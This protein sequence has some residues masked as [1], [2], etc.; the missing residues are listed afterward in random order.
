VNLVSGIG[1]WQSVKVPTPWHSGAF[2]L[3]AI[4]LNSFPSYYE[5]FQDIR[6]EPL[7]DSE[8][9]KYSLYRKIGFYCLMSGLGVLFL[10]HR[11]LNSF[12]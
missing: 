2:F 10:K 9:R 11:R 5:G 7:R 4:G 12:M 8:I 3:L 1:L 6:D